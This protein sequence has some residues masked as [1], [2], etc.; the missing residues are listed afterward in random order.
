MTVARPRAPLVFTRSPGALRVI[1]SSAR[2]TEKRRK[3]TAVQTRR[4]F[5]RTMH[6]LIT[7]TSPVR[8][9]ND[10]KPART[11]NESTRKNST[12]K[13][14]KET[15]SKRRQLS[16]VLLACFRVSISKHGPLGC[17]RY[18]IT[19]R[20]DETRPGAG[21]AL[22]KT[23]RAPVLFCAGESRAA[24]AVAFHSPRPNRS[25]G[26]HARRDA[27]CSP[28]TPATLNP[29]NSPGPHGENKRTLDRLIRR[30]GINQ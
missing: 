25:L 30:A 10:E 13:K 9:A 17:R 24:A 4:L 29:R 20:G 6:P 11:K 27:R 23:R 16:L 22:N 3:N 15:P 26:G 8:R 28:R 2:D 5:Q 18:S 1:S 21:V 14:E 19:P 7:P 12:R